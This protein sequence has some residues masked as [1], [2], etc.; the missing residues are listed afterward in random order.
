MEGASVLEMYFH[1]LP[2]IVASAAGPLEKVNSITMYG[3]GNTEQLVGEVMR[4]ANQIQNAIKE[5]T[6]LD[7]TE[8]ISEHFKKN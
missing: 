1:A 8:L 5:A 7:V 2:Q 3:S 6:G 4:N